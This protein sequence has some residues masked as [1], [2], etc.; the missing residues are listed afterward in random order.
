M[1][2]LPVIEMESFDDI[3]GFFQWGLE[4]LPKEQKRY[5]DERVKDTKV[6]WFEHVTHFDK[7]ALCMKAIEWRREYNVEKSAYVFWQ[8]ATDLTTENKSANEYFNETLAKYAESKRH[9]REHILQTFF[10][11]SR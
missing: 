8:R 11:S 3:M 1:A 7:N 9:V 2:N 10:P 6:Y 4:K 5:S